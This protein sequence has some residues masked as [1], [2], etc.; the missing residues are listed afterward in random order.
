M[1]QYK[2]MLEVSV[3]TVVKGI[4]NVKSSNTN[5]FNRWKQVAA[6]NCLD[7]LLEMKRDDMRIIDWDTL[8]V[9]YNADSYY[10]R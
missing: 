10:R 5:I 4:G 8:D 9:L 1:T 7:S 6:S 2:Y 3:P